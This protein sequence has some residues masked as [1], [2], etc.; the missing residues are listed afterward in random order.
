[1]QDDDGDYWYVDRAS[2]M[3]RTVT[4]PVAT[5]EIEDA[6]YQL[7]EVGLA[8][9]Y[10]LRVPGTSWQMP[11]AAVVPQGS[12]KLQPSVLLE[13]IV[14]QLPLRARPRFIRVRSQIALTDGYRPIKGPLV[15][16]GIRVR[17]AEQTFWYDSERHRYEVLDQSGY[18]EAVRQ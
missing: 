7:P 12:D 3:I 8:V 6:L 18:V 17:S 14:R 9:A 11:V 13:V 16:A 15:E 10:P 1:R 4:G 5:T 2:D